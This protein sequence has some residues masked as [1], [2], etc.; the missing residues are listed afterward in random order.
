MKRE[1][2]YMLKYPCSYLVVANKS[3]KIRCNQ[4]HLLKTMKKS[5]LIQML[6]IKASSCWRIYQPF[7]KSIKNANRHTMIW[8]LSRLTVQ[9]EVV[10][11][12]SFPK[13]TNDGLLNFFRCLSFLFISIPTPHFLCDNAVWSLAMVL[14]L[15][16]AREGKC[17]VHQWP[18]RPG[19]DPRS[20]HTKDSKNGTWCLLA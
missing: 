3:P 9:H 1:V 17:C 8:K 5:F 19:F 2:L 4:C 18:G 14:L 20:S 7:I 10:D 6:T 15:L 16:L 12:S 13:D 11:M